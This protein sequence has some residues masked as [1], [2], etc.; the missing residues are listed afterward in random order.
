MF[1]ILL[2]INGVLIWQLLQ[3][4]SLAQE[5]RSASQLERHATLE[6]SAKR[7]QALVE[8]RMSVTEH[9]ANIRA[10]M[11]SEEQIKFGAHESRCHI[12]GAR[13]LTRRDCLFG[14]LRGHAAEVAT[15]GATV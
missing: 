6:L 11:K 10:N 2:G 13:K 7:E 8:P 12:T 4:N 9:D 14:N 1:L 3:L 15:F 5:A